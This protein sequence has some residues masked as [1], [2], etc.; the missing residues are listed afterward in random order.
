MKSFV[1]A[2]FLGALTFT[3]VQSIRVSTEPGA[4]AHPS[5]IVLAVAEPV[6]PVLAAVKAAP[7]AAVDP[8]VAE[9]VKI[10]KANAGKPLTAEQ[11]ATVTKDI[12][13]SQ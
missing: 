3:E 11:E 10:V 7:A 2:A 5:P 13:E 1:L 12:V 4:I 8:K 6:A 9:A